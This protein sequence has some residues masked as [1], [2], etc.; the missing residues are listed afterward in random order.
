MQ[1]K[2]LAKAVV[3]SLGTMGEDIGNQVGEQNFAKCWD[4]KVAADRLVLDWDN[5]FDK[6][7]ADKN[8][9]KVKFDYEP[10]ETEMRLHEESEQS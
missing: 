9:Y 5:H 3:E 6:V 8:V 7:E 10:E 1:D 2:D 4:C